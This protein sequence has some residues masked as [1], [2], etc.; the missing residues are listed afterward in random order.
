MISGNERLEENG[1]PGDNLGCLLFYLDRDRFN[2]LLKEPGFYDVSKTYRRN[3][4]D[5]SE[6]EINEFYRECVRTQNENRNL[7]SEYGRTREEFC[8]NLADE[9]KECKDCLRV[10]NDY[11]GRQT[12]KRL[13]EEKV[14]KLNPSYATLMYMATFG[15]LDLCHLGL[16]VI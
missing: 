15:Q 3:H 16:G 5:A 2:S 9:V 14:G 4:P 10:Y 13:E 6:N 1:C 12:V 11:L 7:V 8:A